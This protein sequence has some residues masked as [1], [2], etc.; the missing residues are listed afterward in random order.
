MMSCQS[1]NPSSGKPPG[2]SMD[3][4]TRSLRWRSQPPAPASVQQLNLVERAAAKG[5]ALATGGKRIAAPPGMRKRQKRPVAN[6]LFVGELVP[7]PLT[8]YPHAAK[9]AVQ[10]LSEA[11]WQAAQ[12]LRSKAKCEI[13]QRRSAF[14]VTVFCRSGNAGCRVISLEKAVDANCYFGKDRPGNFSYFVTAAPRSRQPSKTT[15][16]RSKNHGE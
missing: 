1:A 8:D 5:A 4:P 15:H 2:R 9:Y 3:S 10:G 14:S 6:R 7:F 12:R 16:K 11:A 13:R